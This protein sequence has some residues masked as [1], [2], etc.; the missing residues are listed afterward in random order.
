MKEPTTRSV[1]HVVKRMRAFRKE[2][3]RLSSSERTLSK[4]VASWD[5]RLCVERSKDLQIAVWLCEAWMKLYGVPGLT[6]GVRLCHQLMVRFW[7]TLYPLIEEGESSY[8]VAPL[9]YLSQ[10]VSGRLKEIPLTDPI[11]DKAALTW[12]DWE[13]ALRNEKGTK[14]WWRDSARE[15]ARGRSCDQ[16]ALLPHAVS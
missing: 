8:R 4:V 16:T 10:R 12:I 1:K 5:R 6:L 2:S 15:C 7:N 3:G 14:W 9:E 11:G 13:R